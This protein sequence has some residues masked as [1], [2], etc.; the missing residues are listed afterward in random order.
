MRSEETYIMTK[1]HLET[2][3][4]LVANL[5]NLFLDIF[6]NYETIVPREKGNS[7]TE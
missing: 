1:E 3:E 5:Q 2:L 7:P 4:E 6:S